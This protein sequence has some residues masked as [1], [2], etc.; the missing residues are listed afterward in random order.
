MLSAFIEGQYKKLP[1][2]QHFSIAWE[3]IVEDI[4]HYVTWNLSY[5][6]PHDED[7]LKFCVV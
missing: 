3:M 4:V 2:E 5:K 6:T 7:F 1:F